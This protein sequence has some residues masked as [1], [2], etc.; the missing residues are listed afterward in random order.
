MAT[1]NNGKHH[2]TYIGIKLFNL[3]QDEHKHAPNIIRFK[4]L[5]T[6]YCKSKPEV[7]NTFDSNAI[8]MS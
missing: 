8:I 5:V 3:L 2:V 6:R 7:C 1:D 4:M